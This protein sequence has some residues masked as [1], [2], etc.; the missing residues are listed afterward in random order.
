MIKGNCLIIIH[1]VLSKV[2]LD[3]NA[4]WFDEFSPE[5]YHAPSFHLVIFQYFRVPRIP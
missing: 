5:I 4:H 3:C 1:G 2:G